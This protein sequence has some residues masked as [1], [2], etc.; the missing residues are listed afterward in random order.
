MGF[1]LRVDY[2]APSKE[3]LFLGRG[4][5]PARDVRGAFISDPTAEVRIENWVLSPR[6]PSEL[7]LTFSMATRSAVDAMIVYARGEFGSTHIIVGKHEPSRMCI[8]RLF[9]CR[10][11][12]QVRIV[13]EPSFRATGMIE[14]GPGTMDLIALD[15]IEL[16]RAP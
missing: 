7:I 4:W 5:E 9:S 1:V 13:L 11:G 2:R 15:E 12:N 3:Q 16:T 6:L 10:A 14:E 8:S